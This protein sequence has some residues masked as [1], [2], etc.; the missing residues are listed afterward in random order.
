MSETAPDDATVRREFRAVV[1]MTPAALR[2]WLGT[3]ESRSV[4]WT[5]EG[6]AESV[7]HESGRHIVRLLEGKGEPSEEDLAHMRKVIGYVHRHLAQ[8]PDGD[9]TGTRWRYSLMNWGHDPLKGSAAARKPRT[10]RV[11]A[12]RTRAAAG[13]A[14]P[15]GRAKPTGARRVAK[16]PTTGT[17]RKPTAKK[18][19]ARPAK[20]TA[21]PAAR[22][23]S[24]RKAAPTARS[25][26]TGRVT[27][28]KAA[29]PTRGTAKEPARSTG[30][31]KPRVTKADQPAT[32]RAAARK[33]PAR[34]VRPAAAK[35]VPK[36]RSTAKA[37]STPRK[38]A[39]K[40][41]ASTRTGAPRPAARR[42]SSSRSRPA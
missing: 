2:R 24:A 20:G 42:R 7:G 32:G 37:S 29:R 28:N 40:K 12:A 27:A 41:P 10:P 17:S 35:A 5:H 4:G 23:T 36:T 3:E 18:A 21:K 15:K 33:A 38:T 31:R 11:G 22:T 34:P 6:E 14:T 39:P 26:A 1:N 16:A 19:P 9:V 13:P 30:A 8:R 25:S